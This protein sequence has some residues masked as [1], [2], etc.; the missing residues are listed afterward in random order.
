MQHDDKGSTATVWKLTFSNLNICKY[1]IQEF[2]R[3]LLHAASQA[4]VPS[5]ETSK[6]STSL[7]LSYAMFTSYKTYHIYITIKYEERTRLLS[8][9]FGLLNLG[10]ISMIICPV[11]IR[12]PT[13]GHWLL[14]LTFVP[15]LPLDDVIEWSSC[16]CSLCI[17]GWGSSNLAPKRV[18]LIVRN[19]RHWL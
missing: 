10:H 19:L 11:V 3:Y 14:D 12:L 9:P 16:L 8:V 2:A 15:S 1:T 13:S 7:T 6:Q 4:S 5:F 17:P 18:W